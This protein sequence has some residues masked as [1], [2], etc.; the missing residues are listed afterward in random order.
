[1]GALEEG[2]ITLADAL[3]REPPPLWIDARSEV[4]YRADHLPGALLL[5]AENWEALVQKVLEMWEP[6]RAAVVYCGSPD[7]HSSR[8]VAERL[9][10]FK[11]G[12]V[13][14]LQGGW[15][16]WKQK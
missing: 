9:R 5:N 16:A 10:D 11:L 1:M 12:P 4:E 3:H 15:Q 14:V 13:F 8:E 2:E 7:A 6:D